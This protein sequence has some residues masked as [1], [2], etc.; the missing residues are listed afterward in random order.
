MAETSIGSTW[1]KQYLRIQ[2][3]RLSHESYLGTRSKIEICQDGTVRETFQRAN[4]ALRSENPLSHFEFALKYD[5]V[6]IDFFRIV[7]KAIPVKHIV[8]FINAGPNSRYSK[9]IGFWYEFLTQ[10]RLPVEDRPKSNYVDL[11]DPKRYMTGSIVKNSRWRI[12]DNLL[13]NEDFCPVIRRTDAI[14]NLLMLDFSD[15]LNKILKSYPPEILKRAN[16]YLYKKETRSSY[17]IEREEPSPER[18]ERFVSLLSNAGRIDIGEL[19]SE[20]SLVKLQNQIVDPRFAAITFRNFQNYIG[21]TAANYDEI[22]HYVCPPPQFLPDLI[23]GLRATAI[24]MNDVNPIARAAAVAFGFVFMHPFEDGNGRIHR[25]LIHDILSR[26][27]FLPAGMIIPVS[28]HMVNNLNRYDDALEAYSGPLMKIIRYSKNAEQELIVL[29]PADVEG[30][31]RFPDLTLQ[32]EYLFK[33]VK[34]SVSRDLPDELVFLQYYDEAKRLIKQRVDMPDKLID[35]FIR[36]THQNNGIFPKRRRTNFMML[37][38]NEIE[39]LQSVF[40]DVFKV[41]K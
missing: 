26:N 22:I 17:Q 8:D 11:I 20:K 24:K 14:S 16:N 32:T 19:L 23:K 2:N 28:A 21:Q 3:V 40:H 15:A 12:N 41:V 4:Y 25:F 37:E 1:L 6:Q 18:I 33:V 35:L 9:K 13:G 29:N 7:L 39:A 27:A 5:D 34:T 30:Y 10:D 36:V 38:D 31:Y